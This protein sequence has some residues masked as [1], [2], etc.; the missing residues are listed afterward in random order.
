MNRVLRWLASVGLALAAAQPASA[1]GLVALETA[2]LRLIYFDPSATYLA[3][4]AARCFTNSLAAQQAR[5]GFDP[6][7]PV[8]VLL[9]DFTDYGNAAAG[10]VPRNTLL[11]DIAPISFVFETFAPS[12]RMYTLMNHELVHVAMMDQAAAEDR[13]ARRWLGGKVTPIPE[14][15][16]SILYSYLTAP[17]VATPRWYLEGSAVFL[18]TWMSGGLGRAQGAYDEM[19]FRSMVRDGARFYDPLGLVSEGTRIDFQVGVNA[20]LYGTR[21]MSY[22]A[23]EHGPGKLIEWWTRPDG[24][25]R[26]YADQFE[27]VYGTTL[28]EAWQRW[29]AFEREFQAANLASVRRHPVTPYRDLVG[30]GLGSVSRAAYD[31]S[32]GTLYAGVRYPGVVSHIAA[33]RVDGGTTRR[34]QDIKDPLLYQVT[35]LALDPAA[36]TLFYTT[37]NQAYRDLVALD[38]ASGEARVLMKDARI[39][40]LA[41]NRADRSLWGIRHLNGLATLVRIAPPYG[42]WQQVH[43]FAYGETLYDLDVSPDGQRLSASFG[44]VSGEQTLRIFAIADLL[45]GRLQPLASRSFGSAAPEAFVFSADGRYLYGSSYYTGVSNVY[46]YEPATDG[47]EALSN[48]ETG[49]FRPVPLSDGRMI[50]MR[51]GGEGFVPAVI[52]PQPLEDLSA[53]RF[54]GAEIAARHPEVRQWRV[55]SPA[56]VPLDDIVTR[57]GPYEAW[58]SV[59][60]ESAYPVL[61]GYKDSIAGGVRAHFS[62][63]ISLH[64]VTVVAAFSPDSA[65]DA[66]EQWHAQLRYE[67]LGFS[68]D[69]RYNYANFYDLF[70][71]REASLKGHSVALAYERPLIYDKPRRLDFDLRAAYYGGLDEVPYF[72]DIDATYD[73]LANLSAGLDYTNASRSLGAVDDEKGWRAGLRL[74]GSYVNGEMIPFAFGHVDLGYALPLR[75][76][77]LW[78]L[79]AAGLAH[80]DED[81]AFANFFFGGFQ[82]NW[83]DHEEVKRYREPFTMPGFE[84]NELGGQSFVKSI[85]EWNLPPLRFRSAGTPG[86]YASWARPALFATALVTGPGDDERTYGNVGAQLDFQ[87]HVM[88]RLDMTLSLGYA[89]GFGDGDLGGHEFMLSLKIL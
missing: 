73:E 68:A 77:S 70:G 71:P 46:R 45:Q 7:G 28:G 56:A 1:S 39:G 34:L 9:K 54:L 81:N 74:G 30:E 51:Y 23:L 8:T 42:A 3:P 88:S 66:E 19:V 31:P 78:W 63:P 44:D 4:Y 82:N 57:Q 55:G 85:L 33:L 84:I 49:F 53:I 59:R 22:L 89:H 67:H 76:S 26:Y 69:L 83:V 48:A 75:H 41:F 14:H 80:G 29:I 40:D 60:L 87:L 38:L 24:S 72:Q 11:V 5:L 2:D 58:Q 32:T 25:R 62:D 10:A 50:V 17:R 12:E 15:P 6:P 47:L 16:E 43:T 13:Q 20:Y 64:G 21:F 18:E 36:Q 86:F 65:L 61:L 52:E 37:D 35:S 27:H 79:N